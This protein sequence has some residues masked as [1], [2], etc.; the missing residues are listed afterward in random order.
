MTP[1]LKAA[2]LMLSKKGIVVNSPT[3]VRGKLQ[4]FDSDTSK[5]KNVIS[6]QILEK[7]LNKQIDHFQHL[8]IENTEKTITLYRFNESSSK[9]N[10]NQLL[11]DR[12]HLKNPNYDA[13]GKGYKRTYNAENQNEM[14]SFNVFISNFKEIL[15]TKNL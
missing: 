7:T 1:E 11:L 13:I 14:N 5:I 4:T 6:R 8:T 10:N 3:P 15:A 12:K 2:I 9:T